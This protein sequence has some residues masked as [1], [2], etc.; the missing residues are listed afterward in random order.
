MLYCLSHWEEGARTEGAK[1]QGKR[2]PWE[3]KGETTVAVTAPVKSAQV[4]SMLGVPA[5]P[6]HHTVQLSHCVLINSSSHKDHL[7]TLELL[8]QPSTLLPPTQIT[9]ETAKEIPSPSKKQTHK[10]KLICTH[11][12]FSAL[13]RGQSLLLWGPLPLAGFWSLPHSVHLSQAITC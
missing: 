5:S 11:P 2:L 7:K 6:G 10:Q 8:S 3:P 13:T 9:Q 1:K 12:P 4:N